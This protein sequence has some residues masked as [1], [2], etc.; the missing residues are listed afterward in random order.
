MNITN[1]A[2]QSGSK[3]PEPFAWRGY[4]RYLWQE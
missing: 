2:I 4:V 3:L 1:K